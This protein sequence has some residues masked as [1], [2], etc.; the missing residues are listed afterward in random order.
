MLQKRA[1]ALTVSDIW[2]GTGYA[3]PRPMS[4]PHATLWV[5]HGD[6]L[7]WLREHPA[8]P[9]TS[10]ITSLPDISELS[11]GFDDWQRWF[12]AAAHSVLSWLPDASVAIFH[13]S[14]ILHAGVWVDKAHLVLRA[15]EAAGTPLVWH[16]IVCRTPPG[17][18]R[19]GRASYSHLLCFRRGQL[20]AQ[21]HAYP[22][23]L[24]SA[25]D[26]TWTRGMGSA[27]CELACRYLRQDTVTARVV[28]P[29]CGHGS[30]LAIARRMGFDVLGIEL[31]KKR[32][33]V[34]RATIGRALSES[35]SRR[36][37][38]PGPA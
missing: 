20:Q 12:M 5:E 24:P 21:R 32:C 33:R 18:A 31:N 10:I 11:L 3:A 25:G 6:G 22:D 8:E 7:A 30:V 37:P 29:F 23:V 13:Q 26:K 17:E 9:R 16:K 15:A 1:L 14:D 2:I 4:D 34:A 36:S 38:E 19:F 35:T 28:D 27:A